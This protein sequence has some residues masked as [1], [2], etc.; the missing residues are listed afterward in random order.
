ME[1]F[2]FAQWA[3]VAVGIIAVVSILNK[4]GILGKTADERGAEALNR[5]EAVTGNSTEFLPRL[6]SY[7]RSRNIDPTPNYIKSIMPTSSQMLAFKDNLIKARGFFNDDES[8][9][10]NVF[11][12]VRSQTQAY[13]FSQFFQAYTKKSVIDYLDEFLDDSELSKINDI[14]AKLPMT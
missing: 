9:V 13:G 14:T 8:K 7:L 5:N 12:N 10:Y 2:A 6:K 4:F 1:A 11:R 3:L